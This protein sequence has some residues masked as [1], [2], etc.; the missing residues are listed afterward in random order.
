M[1]HPDL[2]RRSE[3]G[4]CIGSYSF[5]HYEANEALHVSEVEKA[6]L[7]GIVDKIVAEY[8]GNIDR[9]SQELIVSNIKL[10]L[11]YCTRYYDRQFYT[12]T[13]LNK[14]IAS[15][16]EQL[17]QRYYQNQVYEKLGLP[18]VAYCG[19]EMGISPYYLSDLLKKETGRTASDYIHFFV[20]ERAKNSLLGTQLS[21][22]EVAYNLGFAYPQHFSKLFKAKVGMS[23]KEYR[24]LG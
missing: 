21:V 24:K 18:T 1:F 11:D 5:F 17:L 20:L 19:K 9:H 23:P 10:L 2:I 8:S 3:L 22:T 14:D 7:R 12:R 4:R 16:F 15:Q 13:N 6:C